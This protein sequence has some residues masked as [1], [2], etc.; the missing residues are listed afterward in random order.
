VVRP[1]WLDLQREVMERFDKLTVEELCDRARSKQI[2]SE[3]ASVPDF[4]I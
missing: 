1:I 3:A 2:P 4:S